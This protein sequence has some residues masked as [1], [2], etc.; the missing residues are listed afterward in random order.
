MLLPVP[1]EH[2]AR[3][4][5]LS[6]PCDRILNKRLH[7]SEVAER[8]IGTPG[9]LL[10]RTETHAPRRTPARSATRTNCLFFPTRYN[11]V[12]T[13]EYMHDL[14]TDIYAGRRGNATNHSGV[15]RAKNRLEKSPPA[16]RMSTILFSRG[17]IRF[18]CHRGR[19][20]VQKTRHTAG[21]S[22]C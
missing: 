6:Q 21:V 16:R 20:Q 12:H 17:S 7:A 22:S 8:G 3:P 1:H 15:A 5:A 11:T 18:W 14:I 2:P 4:L 13:P 9:Y 10:I 19:R